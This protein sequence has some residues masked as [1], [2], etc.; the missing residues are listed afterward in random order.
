MSTDLK[1]PDG[2]MHALSLSLGAIIFTL[3]ISTPRSE[4]WDR[5]ARMEMRERVGP[6]L[7]ESCLP[8]PSGRARG[9]SSHNL[10]STFM[11]IS[12]LIWCVF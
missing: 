7:R 3:T 2:A 1:F 8:I 6:R 4:L 12:V 5:D 10:G 9:T 11:R